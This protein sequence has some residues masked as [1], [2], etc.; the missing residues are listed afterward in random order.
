MG[1]P[2]LTP[3]GRL[4][5]EEGRKQRWLARRTGIDESRLSNIVWGRHPSQ[6]EAHAIAQALGRTVAELFP[7]QE[8]AA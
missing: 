4:L 6:D 7:E 1:R 3:L 5:H 2:P 8:A